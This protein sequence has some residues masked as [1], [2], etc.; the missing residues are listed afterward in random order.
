MISPQ[1]DPT[2]LL[3]QRFIQIIKNTKTATMQNINTTSSNVHERHTSFNSAE[4]S[5]SNSSVDVVETEQAE[6]ELI[7]NMDHSLVCAVHEALSTKSELFIRRILV[8]FVGAG[9]DSNEE[10]DFLITEKKD[11]FEVA[12]WIERHFG[13]SSFISLRIAVYFCARSEKKTNIRR[14]KFG[15]N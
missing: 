8:K 3:S 7:G 9:L 5:I 13:I 1:T 6:D 2:S 4:N 14:K 11:V 10:I 15:P 12:D